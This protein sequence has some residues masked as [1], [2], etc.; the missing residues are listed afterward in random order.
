MENI[1]TISAYVKGPSGLVCLSSIP[2]PSPLLHHLP[3]PGRTSLSTAKHLST[4]YISSSTQ[5]APPSATTWPPCS[6]SC[7][8]WLVH[9]APTSW[10]LPMVVN[11]AGRAATAPM[12]SRRGR[13]GSLA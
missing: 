6:S 1:Y 12:A 9:L 3:P 8:W 7:Y 2:T 11:R 10:Y 4:V 5:A 13:G